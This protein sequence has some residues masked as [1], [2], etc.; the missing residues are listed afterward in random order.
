[1]S[2][3]A[4]TDLNAE[5]SAFATLKGVGVTVDSGTLLRL[6]APVARLGPGVA[7]S[8]AARLGDVITGVAA[9]A[10]VTG[11]IVSGTPTVCIG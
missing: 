1:M 9:G 11:Q 4:G 5:A 2:L 3:R 7:C 8:S 10:A 6:Q